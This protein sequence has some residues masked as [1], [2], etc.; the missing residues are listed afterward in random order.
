MMLDARS[1]EDRV[2]AERCAAA[3]EAIADGIAWISRHPEVAREAGAAV[4]RDLRRFATRARRLAAAA[5]RPMCVAVFGP[6]QAGKSYLISALA[7]KGTEPV[8][9][10]LGERA[11]DFV[12]EINPEGGKEA[13]GLVTRFTVRPTP[14]L[15]GSP[16]SVRLL[17]QADVVKILG[18]SFLEDF[19]RDAVQPIPAEKVSALIDEARGRA[20]G[21]AA[22]AFGED[23]VFDL[24]E[25]FDRYFRGHPVILSL[26]QGFWREAAALAPRLSAADRARLFAPLW[27]A[28]P[29]YTE[30]CRRLC[31]ALD[32]LGDP[33]DA[34]LG[35]EALL[36]RETSIIDV[37]TLAGLG[38]PD[39]VGQLEV[40]TRDGRRVTLPRPIVAALTAE[41]RLTLADQPWEFFSST[42][43]L[44]FP[45][46]RSREVL[47]DAEGY[48]A[49]PARIAPLYLRGKVA[50]LYQRYVAEQE[51]T[52][53]LLC[54]GPLNQEVR[55]LPGMVKEWVDAT[56]GPTPEER[57]KQPTALFIVL[58]KFDMEFEEKRGRRE[59]Q[60][61]ASRWATR[62]EA[63]ITRFLGLEH[64]WPTEWTPGKPFAN[65]FWLRNP[66]VLA[67]AI[68]DYDA[69]GREVAV[70][71]PERLARLKAEF[72]AT[73]EVQRHFADP[74]RAWDEA[75]RLNDGGITYLA[76]SLTPVC[77]PALKRG[78]VAARLARLARDAAARL[79]PFHV[80]D[81]REAERK[82]RRAEG[83]TLARHLALCIAK[84][85]FGLL[86]RALMVDAEAL[87]VAFTRLMLHS[88]ADDPREAPVFGA[89]AKA[90]DLADELAAL[91]GEEPAAPAA[92]S[93]SCATIDLADQFAE[94]AL[95]E[96]QE[97]LRAFAADP[98]TPSF[99]L[100]PREQAAFLAAQLA[101]GAAW[102]DLR[103]R[104]AAAIR[105]KAAYR[106]R[107]AEA[108]V[109]PVMIAERM[110]NDYV[111]ALGFDRMPEAERPRNPRDGRIVFRQREAAEDWP[112]LGEQPTPFERDYA[113]DWTLALVALIDRNVDHAFGGIVD[114][115]S[116][117]RLGRIL[118]RLAEAA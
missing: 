83:A 27:N 103:G 25:Y 90:S 36:P 51:L 34:F 113:G 40:A 3:A 19:N 4:V 107:F 44:D 28:I 13:T 39:R 2:L 47:S 46:A 77:N 17:T 12:A 79:D 9:V 24:A 33:D 89:A 88:P 57:A 54:I 82:K 10:M 68:L 76:E 114:S 93:G 18:N 118:S 49:D 96:W 71:E 45:G 61:A 48:L 63:S 21:S 73:P 31:Q 38:T 64:A 111:A 72:L 95:A 108:L 101:A 42:D 78:Q 15:P 94:A 112:A 116:N 56:H 74:A 67:K 22:T 52:S 8:R 65:T 16:V 106:E 5:A 30:T 37:E 32:A 50:Y 20:G 85:R 23:V 86:L 104:I 69:A 66:N 81:D 11:I 97:R 105:A 98:V 115:E 91:F 7:R 62:I 92:A 43:L 75:M 84:Q 29:T 117:A 87:Q 1:A 35:L 100:I 102:Q 14:S 53:M 58:T 26:G 59:D 55:T 41:L 60:A 99:L 109:K 110:I 70:R 6:S 80:S